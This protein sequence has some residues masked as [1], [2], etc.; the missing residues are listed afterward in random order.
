MGSGMKYGVQANFSNYTNLFIGLRTHYFPNH[1][2]V[3]YRVIPF[4][5]N[6]F[7]SLST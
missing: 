3:F 2:F 5:E 1:N 4:A 7:P 6:S